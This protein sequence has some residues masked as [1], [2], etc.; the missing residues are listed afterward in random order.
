MSNKQLL[1]HLIDK[2]EE[3]DLLIIR[4][5][6]LDQTNMLDDHDPTIYGIQINREKYTES[7]KK[8]KSMIEL[9]KNIEKTVINKRNPLSDISGGSTLTIVKN[10]GSIQTMTNIKF[11]KKY[12][13]AVLN[14]KQNEIKSICDER[15]HYW[16]IKF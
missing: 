13:D 10:D 15:G 5:S 4:L 7:I 8:I 9:E 6:L 11:P 16:H 12:T 14:N 2:S 1:T 3:L